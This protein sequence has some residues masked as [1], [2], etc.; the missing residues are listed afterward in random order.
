MSDVPRYI[1]QK[2]FHDA[3]ACTKVPFDSE[4]EALNSA[5]TQ[6]RRPGFPAKMSPYQCIRCER[7]HLTSGGPVRRDGRQ[8]SAEIGA[9]RRSPSGPT[10]SQ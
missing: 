3:G 5:K 6:R 10:S 7:W 2:R 8:F 4:R 9:Q 1:S